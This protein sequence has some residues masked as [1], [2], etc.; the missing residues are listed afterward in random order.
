MNFDT[1]ETAVA[2]AKA[3]GSK[4]LDRSGMHYYKNMTQILGRNMPTDHTCPYSCAEHPG[5]VAFREGMLP[6]TDDIL[7][8]TVLLSVGV[9]DPG[10]G[11][12]FGIN[13]LMD[14]REILEKAAEFRRLTE[15]LFPG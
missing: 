7:E 8:R 12:D 3:I 10:L 13:I 6:K 15:H 1:R 5:D 11:T 4:T 9:T 14:E 2:V